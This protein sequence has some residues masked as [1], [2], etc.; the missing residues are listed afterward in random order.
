MLNSTTL[1][2]KDTILNIIVNS[3]VITYNHTGSAVA[4][5]S[6]LIQCG[7]RLSQWRMENFDPY[8]TPKP[9]NRKFGT[10]DYVRE[11]T[12]RTKFGANP[13]TGGFLS[14]R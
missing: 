10:C 3:T 9:I 8:E 2:I 11:A 1:H 4:I 7:D 5:I 13:S 6:P 12:P 14:N